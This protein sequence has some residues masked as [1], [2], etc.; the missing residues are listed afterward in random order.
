MA[1]FIDAFVIG[2]GEEVI[3]RVVDLAKAA[4]AQ[5]WPRPTLLR[6]LAH[7]RGVYVPSGYATEASPEGWLVPRARPGFPAQ[8]QSA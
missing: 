5:H 8:V 2:D 6:A 4:R 1:E 3:Q 7:V